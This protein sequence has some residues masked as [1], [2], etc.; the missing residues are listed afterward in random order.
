MLEK[1]DEE[2][3]IPV[4][5]HT[6]FAQIVDAFLDGDFQL[7]HHRI[8]GVDPI[9]PSTAE[10]IADCIGAY[11]DALAPLNPQ[12]WDGSVYRWLDGYWE[13]LVD[14]TTE[15][16]PV[17]DLTLHAKLYDEH[18]PRLEIQWVIVP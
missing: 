3:A 16:E 11:G 14:L 9:D 2:H 7:R 18:Q 1:D 12:T 13:L 15:G 6:T 8:A 17:S 5:W 10:W 4:E